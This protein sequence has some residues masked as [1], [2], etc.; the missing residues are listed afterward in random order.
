MQKV[1]KEAL[2]SV[3]SRPALIYEFLGT[4][5]Q[6]YGYNL[7]YELRSYAFF[8]G[9]I[10]AFHVSGAEFNPAISI[11]SFFAKGDYSKGKQLLFVLI[12]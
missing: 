4:A 10:L 2:T 12:A 1:S 6:V 8:I 7:G 11:A 3:M 9:W 5:F